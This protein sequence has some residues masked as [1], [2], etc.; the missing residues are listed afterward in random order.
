MTST[1]FFFFF[2]NDT[3]TTEIYTLS[4]HDALPIC[5]LRQI[6]VRRARQAHRLCE[7][8]LEAGFLDQA[9]D[10][11]EPAGDRVEDGAVFGG[12]LAGLGHRAEVPVRAHQR[13]VDEVAPVCQQLVVRAA[14]ELR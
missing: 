13:A 2:F 9:A 3:A 7:S 10:A 8:R 5:L 12:Q 1:C 11:V 14:H 4:L 6:D